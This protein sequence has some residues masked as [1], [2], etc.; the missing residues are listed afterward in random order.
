MNWRTILV[1][2]AVIFSISL[3]AVLVGILFDPTVLDR[4]ADMWQ[5]MLNA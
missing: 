4:F 1:Y 3:F 2:S 5:G